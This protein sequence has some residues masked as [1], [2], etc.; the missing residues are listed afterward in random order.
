[1]YQRNGTFAFEAITYTAAGTY[2]YVVMEKA[3]GGAEGIKF[4]ETKF[5]VAVTVK[6]PRY[7]IQLDSISDN[8]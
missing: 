8:R 2:Y 3:V 5:V 1:M 7:H 6:D 4:D